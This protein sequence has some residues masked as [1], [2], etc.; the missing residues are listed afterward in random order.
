[1]IWVSS[2]DIFLQRTDG[3]ALELQVRLGQPKREFENEWSCAVDV[4]T[5]KPPQLIRGVSSLQALTLALR[6]LRSQLES[7][8]EQGNLLDPDTR[9]PIDMNALFGTSRSAAPNES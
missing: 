7:F 3:S 6:F 1:M 2:D 5:G 8:A 4:G 9:E